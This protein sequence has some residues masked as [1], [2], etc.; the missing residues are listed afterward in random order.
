MSDYDLPSSWLVLP[1]AGDRTMVEIQHQVRKIALRQLLTFPLAQLAPET[2]RPLTAVRRVLA[3]VARAQSATLFD[4]LGNPDVLTPLLVLDAGEAVTGVTADRMIRAAVPALLA[5][6]AHRA[7]KGAIP[8]AVLWD[9]PIDALPDATGL[10]L[11]RFDPPARGLTVDPLGLELRLADGRP[12]RV[13]E[14]AAAIDGVPGLTTERPF[15]RVHPDLPRLCLST[16]DSNPLSMFEAHPDKD[17][18]AISL[19]DR[20]LEAWLDAL[21]RALDIV[22]DTLP[23]WFEEI[24]VTARRFVPVGYLPERHLSATYREAPSVAYLT[25]CESTMTMAEALIHETQ[26]TK[27]NLLSYVDPVLHNGM[28]C[29]TPSPVRPD[30]RPLWGVLLAVH[31]FVP[32]A[33]MHYRLAALDH[34]VTQTERFP[35]RRAEVI[36]GNHRGMEIVLE[37]SDASDQGR[38]MIDEMRALHEL[39]R[40]RTPPPPPGMDIDP[41]ILPPG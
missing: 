25:L 2:R 18:N 5:H 16:Y 26:H 30:L 33:A 6:L 20:S 15:H 12:V 31:A 14:G 34:P 19:G 7:R 38:R 21:R 8:E 17:G 3:D 35:R 1:T 11:F 23:T 27:V 40:Q 37:H 10:R 9:L 28:T 39:L 29:W 32:V 24:K 13:P 4:A 22:R 41:E 36:A